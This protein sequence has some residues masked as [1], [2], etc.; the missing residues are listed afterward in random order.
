M[1]IPFRG[2]IYFNQPFS[3]LVVFGSHMWHSAM[4]KLNSKIYCQGLKD[5]IHLAKQELIFAFPSPL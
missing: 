2:N 4:W 1:V 5:C 3:H